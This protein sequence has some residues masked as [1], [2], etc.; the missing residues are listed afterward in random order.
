MQPA[1]HAYELAGILARVFSLGQVQEGIL[2]D[3]I[4]E[5]Y[6]YAGIPPREWID[7]SHPNWPIF[8]QVMARLREQ[9]RANALVTKLALF[10]DLGLFPRIQT[11][12]T[13]ADFIGKRVSLKLSDLPTDEVKSALAEIIIV[14]LHGCALRGEQ[15]RQLKRMIVFDEAH[16]VRNSRRLEALA[17]EGRAFGVGIVIGTQFPGDIPETMA[18]NLATQLFLMNNQA[19]HRRFVVKQVFG[20]TSGANRRN[21]SKA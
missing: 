10:T 2:R 17:R 6:Q 5:T 8:D 18:G 16:R 12:S 7:P 3:A 1:E 19:Q 20:T 13:F 11:K 21:C 15:P 9:P 4:N 14:Q